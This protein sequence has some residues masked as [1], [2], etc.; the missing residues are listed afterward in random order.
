MKGRGQT[1]CHAAAEGGR[2]DV[3]AL[4][5]ARQPNL[6]AVDVNGKTAFYYAVKV[7]QNDDGR[8]ALMLL[9]AGASLDGRSMP[10]CVVS[11]RRARLPSRRYSIVASLCA[12]FVIPMAPR[13]CTWPLCI[14][15]DADVFDML[16]DVCGIDLGAR[17]RERCNMFPLAARQECILRFGGSSQLAPT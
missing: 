9:E 14:V 12:S 6:A 8:C 4:L 5:L 13:C 3:L 11:L 10:T 1:A 2:H 17:D 15:D 7:C 16:V